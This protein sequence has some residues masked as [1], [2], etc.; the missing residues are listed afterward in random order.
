MI[1]KLSLIIIGSAALVACNKESHTI[2]GGEQPDPMK[3]ELANAAPVELP[4]AIAAS[5]SYRC[6]DN[7]LL[8]IDWYSDGSA[9][10]KASKSEVG[11]QVPA[12]VEGVKPTLTGDAK[13]ASISYNG[14]SC[15]G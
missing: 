8:Y 5:K 2:V 9:R 14:L 1:R 7:S 10:V 6:K 15:K 12:P 4:P 11:T 3:D 13:S